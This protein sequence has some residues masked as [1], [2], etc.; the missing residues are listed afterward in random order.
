MNRQKL[1][2]PFHKQNQKD[3]KTNKALSTFVLKSQFNFLIQSE[4]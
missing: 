1:S 2:L 3:L 4:Q